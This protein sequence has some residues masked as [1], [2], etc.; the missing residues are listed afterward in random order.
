MARDFAQISCTVWNSRK[1]RSLKDDDAA[2]LLYFYL[3][4]NELT[5]NVGC[6][7]LKIGAVTEDIG[8]T[9][10]KVRKALDSLCK[11]DLI[12]FDSAERLVR[13]VGFLEKFPTTNW[14]HAAGC[15]RVAA[16][17]PDCGEKLALFKS[18]VR[19]PHAGDVEGLR[20]AFDSLSEQ[21]RYK[22]TDTETETDTGTD[23][24]RPS[25]VKAERLSSDWKPTEKDRAY[26]KSKNLT[27]SEIDEEA[28]A[29]V[30]YWAG[31]D[32]KGG[33][34]KKDWHGTWCNRIDTVADRI[35]GRRPRVV[36]GKLSATADA[37]PAATQRST[38]IARYRGYRE[39][40]FWIPTFG[41]KPPK[42]GFAGEPNYDMPQDVMDEVDKEFAPADDDMP[43]IPSF[44]KCEKP[45]VAA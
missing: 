30:R 4:S 34:K 8:W 36:G 9:E 15:F 24:M 12:G 45:E 19:D 23:A 21:Y 22:E 41:P 25:R 31:P 20:A 33:G 1:L 13:I 10:G 5:N 37:T 18:L 40:D 3:H 38:Y 26:A 44:L 11:A 28:I 2:R 43:P 29:F 16:A 14:K 32:A 42:P 7:V 6:Y 39:R 17:L 27:D 35:I